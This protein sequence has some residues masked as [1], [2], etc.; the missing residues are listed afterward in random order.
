[1][2][3]TKAEATLTFKD[4]YVTA[5][6]DGG[7]LS[8][9]LIRIYQPCVYKTTKKLPD[10]EIGLAYT[11]GKKIVLWDEFSKIYSFEHVDKNPTCDVARLFTFKTEDD[12]A[13]KEPL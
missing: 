13:K 8:R 6:T 1:M 4:Y 9:K 10:A 2:T 3:I 12:Y 7:V 11:E 5:Y